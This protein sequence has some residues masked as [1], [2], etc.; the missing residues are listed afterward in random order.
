M[1]VRFAAVF[2]ILVAVPSFCLAQSQQTRAQQQT[3]SSSQSQQTRSSQQNPLTQDSQAP[4]HVSGN[5]MLQKAFRMISPVYPEIAKMAHVSGMV[6]LH[7]LIAKDGTVKDLKV[8]SGPDLLVG[9]TLEAV[10]QWGYHPTLLNGQPVEVDTTVTVIFSL[11]SGTDRPPEPAPDLEKG[12]FI[13]GALRPPLIDPQ[14]KAGIVKL[15]NITHAVVLGQQTANDFSLDFRPVILATLPATP[16]RDQ[17]ADAYI[18][19]LVALLAGQEVFDR[20]TSIY[21]EHFSL[22]D[23]NAMIQFYQTP[24][25]QKALSVMP[26]VMEESREAGNDVARENLPRILAELCKEYPELHGKVKFCPAPTQSESSH[27]IR[28]EL[29]PSSLNLTPSAGAAQ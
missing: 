1:R 27:L 15:L 26:K 5:L 16:H 7:A 8:I 28:K 18:A 23:V 20:L 6:V 2:C 9:A 25:G 19:K 24:A 10:K 13:V 29:R 21:A 11:F 22:E 4:L 17:I 14:L 3:Q 12:A